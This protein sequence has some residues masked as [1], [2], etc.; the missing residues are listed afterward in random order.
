MAEPKKEFK[1]QKNRFGY[2]SKSKTGKSIITVEQDMTLKKGDKLIL[3][4]PQDNIESLL[5]NGFIDEATAEKRKATIPEWKT[6]EVDVLP[7]K[8]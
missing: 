6:H 5:R 8:E 1:M 7:N 2:V 3:N 4:K